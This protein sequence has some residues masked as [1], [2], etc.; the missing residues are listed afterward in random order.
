MFV[1]P[2]PN[3]DNG[4]SLFMKTGLAHIELTISLVQKNT[5]NA[6]FRI[7]KN[8]NEIFDQLYSQKD[9]IE[10]EIGMA[11]EWDKGENKKIS[12]FGKTLDID[13]NNKYNWEKAIR[14]QYNMASK[15]RNVLL[16]KVKD[17]N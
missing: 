3:K 10:S 4:Y 14:W 12:K 17:L 5:I 2:I 1:Y 7:K 15:L 11:L 9:P 6:H 8:S 16:P 13:I